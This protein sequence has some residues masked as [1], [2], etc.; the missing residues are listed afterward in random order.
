MF[1]WHRKTA[2]GIIFCLQLSGEK[3]FLIIKNIFNCYGLV[4]GGINRNE[5][6]EETMLR[7]ME[8]EVGIKQLDVINITPIE[9]TI[10]LLDK[11]LFLKIISQ[12]KFFIIQVKPNLS[13]KTNWEIKEAVWLSVDE[14]NKKFNNNSKLQNFFNQVISRYVK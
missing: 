14:V 8:E 11:I 10:D 4:G 13:L 1:T 9:E 6:A 12:P 5:T 3:Q 7:E 2:A